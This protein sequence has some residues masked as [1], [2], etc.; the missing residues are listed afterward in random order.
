MI[1]DDTNHKIGFASMPWQDVIYARI[2]LYL[3]ATEIFKLRRVSKECFAIVEKYFTLSHELDLSGEVRKMVTPEASDIM[4]DNAKQ[5]RTLIIPGASEWLN[6]KK[7]EV[8]LQRNHFITTLN[9]ANNSQLTNK[10]LISIS[11]HC[12][13]LKELNISNCP[14]A[15]SNELSSV[16]QSNKHLESIDLSSCWNLSNEVI[17][18]LIDCCKCVKH[19]NLS[20]IYS[21]QDTTV[22]YIAKNCK[23]IESLSV[24]GCWRVDNE[25]IVLLREYAK[26]L[27]CLNV[28]DCRSVTEISLARLRVRGVAVNIPAPKAT[29]YTAP[30]NPNDFHFKPLY[31]NI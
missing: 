14:W 5:L 22:S 19:L 21:L 1:N 30:H 27:K 6:D 7:L 4:T 13:N 25:S 16:I 20:N 18:T 29:T 24:N 3:N 12:A 11:K 10:V 26:K 28:S 17:L 31:L 15:E 23:S 9:I 8:M 2:F